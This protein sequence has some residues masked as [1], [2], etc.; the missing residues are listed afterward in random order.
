MPRLRRLP[1][2]CRAVRR[3]R[4]H[5]AS[6]RGS[7]S[8][9]LAADGGN[10]DPL[11][12]AARLA[13]SDAD[14]RRASGECAEAFERLRDEARAR[15]PARLRA[16][17]R[18]RRCWRR[19]RL[20]TSSRARDSCSSRCRSPAPSTTCSP[21][22]R[23]HRGAPASC[24]SSR[25]RSAPRRPGAARA[26]ARARGA[27]AAAGERDEPRSGGTVLEAEA[28]GWKLVEAG[29][30]AGR[31]LRRAPAHAARRGSTRPTRSSW[32]EWGRRRRCRSSTGSALGL[33]GWRP[34]PSRAAARDA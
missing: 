15:A 4:C 1:F 21:L 11:R 29:D 24:R 6:R 27:L 17:A 18:A 10:G 8:A 14:A 13:G 34:T 3:R 32:R 22:G 33:S 26:G 9:R 5:D 30:A 25:T 7:S 19:T 31:R 20:A 12:D 2:A 23:A 16:D 28:L